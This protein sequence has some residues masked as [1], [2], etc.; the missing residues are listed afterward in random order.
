M[1]IP[2]ATRWEGKAVPNASSKILTLRERTKRGQKIILN[3]SLPFINLNNDWSACFFHRYTGTG[4]TT[5]I[6]WSIGPS[7]HTGIIAGT[8]EIAGPGTLSQ[9]RFIV[10]DTGG[11]AIID[12]N[13]DLFSAET[14]EHFI[15]ITFNASTG[16]FRLYVNAIEVYSSVETSEFM[17]AT[18]NNCVTING[19][20]WQTG[21]N[22]SAYDSEL[23]HNMIFTKELSVLEISSIYNSAGIIPYSLHE[24]VYQHHPLE[25]AFTVGSSAFTMVKT[26]TTATINTEWGYINETIAA[27]TD[28]K[29]EFVLRP[30]LEQQNTFFIVAGWR[31]GSRP[32]SQTQI[33]GFIFRPENNLFY[34]YRNGTGVIN[35]ALAIYTGCRW[36]IERIGTTFNVYQN[37]VLI[38]TGTI[39][40]GVLYFGVSAKGEDCNLT[41]VL[42]D[43]SAATLDGVNS[44]TK[45]SSSS[46]ETNEHLTADVIEQYNYAKKSGS[47]TAIADAGGGDIR[48]SAAT[49]GMTAGEYVNI[50]NTTSYDGTYIITN[51]NDPNTFDV[52]STFGA[53]ETGDWDQILTANHGVLINYTDDEL[54]ITNPSAQTAIKDF[55]TKGIRNNIGYFFSGAENGT[56]SSATSINISGNWTFA[57]KYLPVKR[58]YAI[59]NASMIWSGASASTLFLIRVVGGGTFTQDQNFEF[60]WTDGAANKNYILLTY[61]D[62]DLITSQD[63]SNRQL[64]M[65]MRKTGTTVDVFL[66]GVLI[67]TIPEAVNF[68][69]TTLQ[70]N[71]TWGSRDTGAEKLS[72]VALAKTEWH[73]V[74]LDNSAVIAICNDKPV[75]DTNLVFRHNWNTNSTNVVDEKG[76]HDITISAAPSKTIE[77]SSVMP[78]RTKALTFNGTNQYLRVP[79]FVPTNELGYTI[80][81]GLK[82]TA[83]FYSASNG[84]WGKRDTIASQYFVAQGDT[85]PS[86]E[87][88]RFSVNGGPLIVPLLPIGESAENIKLQTFQFL[89]QPAS[90]DFR[91]FY[92]NGGIVLIKGNSGIDSL[93]DFSSYDGDFTVGLD[94]RASGARFDGWIYYFAFFK[95]I[96]TEKELFELNN[97]T[98]LKNP[99]IELQNKYSLE[100][101]IDFDNPYDDAGTLKFPD[102][103][104]N[105]HDVIAEGYTDLATLQSN[106]VDI[107]SLR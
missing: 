85:H 34:V 62:A 82:H 107:D 8:I 74:A 12:T 65:V 88:Y 55:Y 76:A 45:W 66:N 37:N 83:K 41:D 53:T 40:T 79:N 103:S 21:N 102:L 28:G 7:W 16:T 90:S 81:T 105:A 104:P 5:E 77:V 24:Y 54:G 67:Y 72:N 80:I 44:D 69:A 23:S 49:H 27:S 26:G 13:Q 6:C 46:G 30:D 61:S 99:S 92:Y 95:G 43:G 89:P 35:A 68:D 96:L 91:A 22:L 31:D 100:L 3:K 58:P 70:A 39:T 63:T 32:T 17:N 87:E 20:T 86:Q 18:K 19:V 25:K 9:T 106:L 2:A 71:T 84:I 4:A 10:R 64:S 73:S 47:I 48:V 11:T 75:D 29:V 14:D 93:G 52:T 97:N 101:F 59:G 15:A 56:M 33:Y 51:V 98:L 78:P 57:W 94:D 42:I 1:I 36:K 38:Y 60:W 50:K